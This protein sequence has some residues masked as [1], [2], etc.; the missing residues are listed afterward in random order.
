MVRAQI[1]I[2]GN[3]NHRNH[4][5]CL[6]ACLCVCLSVHL[7]VCLYVSL[8]VYHPSLYIMTQLKIDFITSLSLNRGITP[9]EQ[10]ERMARMYDNRMYRLLLIL[11]LVVIKYIQRKWNMR[12]VPILHLMKYIVEVANYQFEN[13]STRCH[14]GNKMYC[15]RI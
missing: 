7:H 2:R 9:Y 12:H 11:R 10:F 3:L 13:V 14:T 5:V 1:L 6:S 4:S 15:L 8:S